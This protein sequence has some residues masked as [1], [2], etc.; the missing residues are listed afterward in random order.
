MLGGGRFVL[1]L[2]LRYSFFRSLY[3][4][5]SFEGTIGWVNCH[6]WRS[7][8]WTPWRDGETFFYRFDV[9]YD[10]DRFLCSTCALSVSASY[11][12]LQMS[13]LFLR[14]FYTEQCIFSFG[15]CERN[16][17]IVLGVSS[18]FFFTKLQKMCVVT[19]LS[20]GKRKL[21]FVNNESRRLEKLS[22]VTLWPSLVPWISLFW[23]G[24]SN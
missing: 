5:I 8:K 1:L 3:F 17:D 20:L 14:I 15:C 4:F 7:W 23:Q 19:F 13:G 11:C 22:G 18:Y 16:C 10:L 6:P 12:C 9:L 2:I 21:Y 24:I